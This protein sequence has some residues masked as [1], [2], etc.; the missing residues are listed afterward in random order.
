MSIF[1]SS[2]IGTIDK[3]NR[4]TIPSNFKS[5]ILKSK[6]NSYLF[7]SLKNNCFEIYLENQI[8]SIIT[9]MT[10]EDFF[11]KKKDH[12]RTAILSDLEEINLDK[13]GRFV[14]KEDH[15]KFCQLEKEIIFIGKGRYFEIWDKYKG[16]KYKEESR[17]K[18]Q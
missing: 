1:I 16:I 11:S 12:L 4:I 17:K 15:K 18:L 5:T 7:R 14:L 6:E 2:F 9:S 8:Q 3:K 13:E 10:E